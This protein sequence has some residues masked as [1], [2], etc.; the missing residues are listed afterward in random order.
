MPQ[1]SFD[2]DHQPRTWQVTVTIDPLDPNA[3][4]ELLVI[5][6]SASGRVQAHGVT[7]W[8][9]FAS[10]GITDAIAASFL[11]WW[12]HY[13]SLSARAAKDMRGRW[14]DAIATQNGVDAP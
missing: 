8:P 5:A 7:T 4:T 3:P 2:Q 12:H 1:L 13:P 11:E 14:L 9:S 6:K 10:E